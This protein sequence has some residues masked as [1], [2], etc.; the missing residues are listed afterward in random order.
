MYYFYFIFRGNITDFNLIELLKYIISGQ[1]AAPFYFIIVIMQ[2]Y[3]L[4][5]LWLVFCKKIHVSIGILLAIS[6]TSLTHYFF[7]NS[8]YSNYCFTPY[9][10]YWISGCYIGLN[11]DKCMNFLRKIKKPI[12]VIGILFTIA[13]TTFAYMLSINE[14]THLTNDAV[15]IT[16][17]LFCLFASLMYLLLIKDKK[18]KFIN[19]MSYCTYYV[20]LIH[21]LIIFETDYI[22]TSFEI[23]ALGYRFIIRLVLTFLL[24]FG[25]SLVCVGIKKLLSKK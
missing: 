12:I 3:I 18:N 21:S 20:Y 4:A 5:P 15:E 2:F 16:R 25:L 6:I 9:L 19:A 1:L 23:N 13:Y 24:P 7:K 22:M 10:I 14:N 17:I 8:T 11:F